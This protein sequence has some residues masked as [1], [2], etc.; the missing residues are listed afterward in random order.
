VEQIEFAR[1]TAQ[2]ISNVKYV[3]GDA[4]RLPFNNGE[5]D[6]V[7]TNKMKHHL[8]D[9]ESTV[10]EMIRVLRPGGYLLYADLVFPR[11]L[12][13]L[14]GRVVGERARL[15]TEAGLD[16][17]ARESNLQGIHWSRFGLSCE[18]VWHRSALSDAG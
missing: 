3:E 1:S 5:F 15:P 13:R 18:A 10:A 11:W 9:W 6:L 17:I 8:P 16:R 7:A 2:E 12:V 4:T 14:A